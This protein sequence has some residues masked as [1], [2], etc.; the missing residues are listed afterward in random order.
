MLSRRRFPYVAKLGDCASAD[1]AAAP[2]SRLQPLG[3]LSGEPYAGAAPRLR[4]NIT[5]QLSFVGGV[6]SAI[7][8]VRVLRYAF[9]GG[10]A[11]LLQVCLLTLFIE[12]ADMNAVVAST[13]AL[14]I[15]VLVNYSLQ[16]RVTFRSKSKH[17]VAAPRFAL[18]TLCTLAANAVLFNGLLAVLP[19]IAAQIVTLGAIFPINYYL[20]RTVTFRL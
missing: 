9:V 14:S 8:A 6:L 19:Y 4:R 5:R 3:H 15:S 10:C 16:H 18:L 20:N 2:G 12:L 7:F 11:A 17:T 13:L 1:G